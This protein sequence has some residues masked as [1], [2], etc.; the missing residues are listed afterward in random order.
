MTVS[1]DAATDATPDSCTCQRCQ[2]DAAIAARIASARPSAPGP[3]PTL[4]RDELL[5]KANA[6]E[7]QYAAPAADHDVAEGL[8][9][10]AAELAPRPAAK[11]IIGK[12]PTAPRAELESR[13]AE[14][15]HAAHQLFLHDAPSEH[16]ELRTAQLDATLDDL[17]AV[18]RILVRAGGYMAPEDQVALRA[19]MAR[20]AEHGR[21]VEDAPM[22]G[23]ST[24]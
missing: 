19:A 9:S 15:R 7:R 6:I 22:T 1:I 13:I 21:S 4:T 20:L 24:R 17:A 5:A 23:R 14:I 12:A 18:T 11:V 16:L 8:L 2:S 10:R 3:L